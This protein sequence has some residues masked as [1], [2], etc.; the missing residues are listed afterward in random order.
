MVGAL[1]V[2]AGLVLALFSIPNSHFG[3]SAITAAVEGLA[4]ASDRGAQFVFGY[5]RRFRLFL[6]FVSCR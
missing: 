2:Q 1:A 3:L 6:V 4:A 5:L